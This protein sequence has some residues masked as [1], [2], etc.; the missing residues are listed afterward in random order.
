MREG[1]R[2]IEQ[3]VTIRSLSLDTTRQ[4]KH[5]GQRCVEAEATTNGRIHKTGEFTGRVRAPR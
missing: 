3:L 4:I 5:T 1:G 2:E